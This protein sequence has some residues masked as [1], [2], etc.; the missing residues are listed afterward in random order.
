MTERRE[1]GEREGLGEEAAPTQ[2]VVYTEKME[3]EGGRG[4]RR[5]DVSPS[6]SEEKNSAVVQ[7]VFLQT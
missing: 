4:R 1:G 2:R 6:E 7:A 5:W 3:R